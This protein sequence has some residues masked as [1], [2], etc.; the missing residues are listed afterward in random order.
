MVADSEGRM[1]DDLVGVNG[2][3]D[4][5]LA[6]HQ[7]AYPDLVTQVT[8]GLGNYHS[9]DWVPLSNTTTVSAAATF[10]NPFAIT[11][12]GLPIVAS[13]H[14]NDGAGG[15]Y[16]MSYHYDSP[17]RVVSG[18]FLGFQSVATTDGRSND[19]TTATWLINPYQAHLISDVTVTQ[20]NGDKI[21]DDSYSYKEHWGVSQSESVIVYHWTTTQY[22]TAGNEL[23]WTKRDYTYDANEEPSAATVTTTDYA[24]NKKWKNTVTLTLNSSATT[25]NWCLALPSEADV[26]QT[27]PDNSSAI[28]QT[29]FT[30][31]LS[32]CREGDVTTNTQNTNT[33]TKTTLTYDAF[34]NVKTAA[35]VGHNAD[36]S[37]MATRT[38]NYG[39]D[40]QGEFQTSTKDP[41]GETISYGWDTARG[42]KTSQ[43]APNG[44]TTS[45][46]YDGFGRSTRTTYPSGAYQILTWQPC[47][48]SDCAS[49]AYA[50]GGMLYTASG[51]FQSIWQQNYDSF[52]RL[53]AGGR[54]LVL[55]QPN[56]GWAWSERSYNTR[57]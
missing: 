41:L 15:S 26:T 23:Y 6:L 18:G 47:T 48:G 51:S 29:S 27:L 53:V 16:T 7:G 40:S 9:P 25:S 39:Y 17:A 37:A 4:I 22:D 46:V 43:T 50:V 32:H 28:R 52:G 45:Y 2:S 38:T 21:K 34:G 36:G 44:T 13:Y 5:E 20:P 35:V 19:T 56:D 8:D 57:G 11:R 10:D 24:T 49:A 54:R 30:P 31:N 3:G 1:L 42:L 33:S 55:I 12:R 14:A